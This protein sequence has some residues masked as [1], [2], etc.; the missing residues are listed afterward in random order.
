MNASEIR[1]AIL[2]MVRQY[3]PAAWPEKPFVAGETAVPCAGRVF[4]AEELAHLVDASLDFWLTTGRYAARFE[5][6]LAQFMG[7]RHASLCN[8]GS[9]ANLL[10]LSALTA[11]GLGAKQ[12][13][14]GDEVI[15]V[16]SGFPTTVNPIFQNRLVPVFL[17]IEPATCNIEVSRLEEALSPRTRAVMLAHTLGNPFKLDAVLEFAQRHGLWLVEDNCDALGSTYQGRFTGTFGDLATLSFYPAHHLTMGEGG[18]VVTNQAQLKTLVESFRDWGRDCWCDPGR[19]NTCGKRF[20]WQLG[21]L[22]YGYD[23]KYIY[24]HL[25]YNLKLTDMQAAVGVAQLQK[26]PHFIEKRKRNWRI[27]YEGLKPFAEFLLLPQATPGSDPAWFGFLLT[28]RTAAPFGRHKLVTYLED[29]KIA[30]RLLFGGNLIRQPAYRNLNFRVVGGLNNSD[31]V[32]NH[33]FWIGVYPGLTEEH[34]AY[35]LNVFSD[36]FK[37]NV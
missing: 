21:E 22:P 16:A 4:D 26:L 11:P 7:V 25:G 33:S 35:V 9:S 19:D 29:R 27:L 13:Q 5:K 34:L 36:F 1:E 15:T 20:Q 30:T 2:E 23:H 32:M 17:D 6:E 14:P 24:S 12:I 8:S 18:C 28:V 37:E 3:Y 10:A 31:L